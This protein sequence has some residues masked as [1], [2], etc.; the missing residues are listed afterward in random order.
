MSEARL[1][2]TIIDDPALVTATQM[3]RWCKDFDNWGIVDTVCFALLH[4]SAPRS[5]LSPR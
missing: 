1:I 2:A 3:D 4:K 5:G